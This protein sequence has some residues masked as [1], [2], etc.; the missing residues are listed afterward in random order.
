MRCFIAIDLDR[1]LLPNIERLQK[2]VQGYDVK[3]VEPNNLHFTLKFLGEVDEK[4]I[5]AA[6]DA[7]QAISGKTGPFTANI[8][9]IGVF[10]SPIFIRVV[11]IGCPELLNLHKAVAEEVPGKED[12]KANPH[13]TIARV[14]SQKYRSEIMGFVERHR[15]DEIGR[16]AI[17]EIKLKKSTVTKSGP[18]YEDVKTFRL[19]SDDI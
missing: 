3:L 10:P 17:K 1:T 13:L 12:F 15:N 16:M 18:I 7:L 8:K 5:L 6:C 14:R 2:E 11:W 4:Q 9:N 19:R